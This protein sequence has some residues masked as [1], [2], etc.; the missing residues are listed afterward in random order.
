M[1]KIATVPAYVTPTI[2]ELGETPKFVKATGGGMLA[3]GYGILS[4]Y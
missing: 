3:L 4:V 1:C 2:Q